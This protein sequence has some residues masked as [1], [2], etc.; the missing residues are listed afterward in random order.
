V[1]AGLSNNT[2]YEVIKQALPVVVALIHFVAAVIH[3]VAATSHFVA[4][5]IHFMAAVVHFVAAMAEDSG[6]SKQYPVWCQTS[7]RRWIAR[8]NK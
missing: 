6:V 7:W 5:V 4:A 3:F 2:S 1:T 8:V